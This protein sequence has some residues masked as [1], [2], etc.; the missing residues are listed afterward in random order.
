MQ[1]NKCIYLNLSESQKVRDL[2]STEQ[3]ADENDSEESVGIG[4]SGL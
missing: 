3:G 4:G 1:L 2:A